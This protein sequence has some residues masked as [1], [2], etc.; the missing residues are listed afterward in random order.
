MLALALLVPLTVFA[1]A[2]SAV[3]Y[4]VDLSGSMWTKVDGTE[5]V[6]LA[7]SA[8]S[9]AISRLPSNVDV[10]LIA[11]GH[12][13]KGDCNDIELLAPLGTPRADIIKKIS[14]FTPKGM[15][16]LTGTIELA[17]SHIKAH[18]GKGTVVILGDGGESCKRDPCKAALG[19]GK[20]I[21]IHVV[22][23]GVGSNDLD[24]LGC[25]ASNGG[26]KYFTADS[27]SSL[28][29]AF[30]SIARD[31]ASADQGAAKKESVAQPAVVESAVVAPESGAS[32]VKAKAAAEK[33]AAEKTAAD[34]AAAV[35]AAAVKAAAVKAAAVKAAAVKAA[36]VKAAAAKAVA[37]KA[38]AAKAA[39]EKA[40]AEKAAAEKAAAEK[41]AAEKA[42]AEKAAAEKA[43]AEKAAVE[44]A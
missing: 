7:R 18:G 3:L 36:A 32:A 34:K 9:E 12:R 43:A 14:S 8:I 27:A 40:A 22:G 37:E 30:A 21:R 31:V 44:K 26:G 11:Y 19:A 28:A 1:A 35:K 20:D 5:K 38:A 15:T 33:A 42:A 2:N 10:G 24:Q 29:S 17:I 39:A 16:P 25:V 4:V 41:A 23:F 6:Y 13:E